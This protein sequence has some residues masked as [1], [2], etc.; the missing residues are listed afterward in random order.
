MLL[1]AAALLNLAAS[2][3]HALH[4]LGTKCLIRYL[5]AYHDTLYSTWLRRGTGGA[6]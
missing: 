6:L 4:A 3:Q 1:V 2:R 5:G